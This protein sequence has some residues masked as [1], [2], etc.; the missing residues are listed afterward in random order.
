MLEYINH[1]YFL[2]EN[3]IFFYVEEMSS[4]QNINISYNTNLKVK[5]DSYNII[6]HPYILIT[7]MSSDPNRS[8]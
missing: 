2:Q 3:P 5:K 4:S 7:P 1:F 6:F 8:T